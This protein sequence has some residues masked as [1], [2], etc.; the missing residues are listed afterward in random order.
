MVSTSALIPQTPHPQSADYVLGETGDTVVYIFPGG[1]ALMNRDADQVAAVLGDYQE[2][3]QPQPNPTDE[4]ALIDQLLAAGK[5]TIA[6]VQVG[7]YD[8][9]QTGLPLADVL[10]ARGWI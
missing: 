3:P 8:Q 6:Q 2:K 1:E 4:A 10:A 7:R 5:L 9:E